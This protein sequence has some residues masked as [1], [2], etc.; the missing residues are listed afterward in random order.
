[1]SWPCAKGL[2]LRHQKYSVFPH[3]TVL[4]NV[5]IGREFAQS[6]LLG[7]LFGAE[8]RTARDDAAT[9][10]ASVGLAGNE[11]KYP[12]ALSGGMQQR[13]ALT[14]A[15]RSSSWMNPSARSILAFA[16]TSIR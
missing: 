2:P 3:L 15:L 7:R 10:L 12:A 5:M 4:D 9:L 13:L 1:M 6:R 16:A 11:S 8:R 14:Q